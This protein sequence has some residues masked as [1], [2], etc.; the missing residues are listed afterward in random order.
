[1]YLV[2]W[3]LEGKNNY[4]PGPRLEGFI[5]KIFHT[6][7]AE[8]IIL[9]LHLSSQNKKIKVFVFLRIFVKPVTS[10]SGVWKILKIKPSNL[11]P[12]G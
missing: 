2:T 4:P 3:I 10:A 7:D 8:V 6:P 9:S 12:G 1:M 5:F 11:G